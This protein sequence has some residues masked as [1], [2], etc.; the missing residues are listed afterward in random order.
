MIPVFD[1]GFNHWKEGS[2]FSQILEKGIS[3]PQGVFP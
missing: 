1:D 3:S 2:P